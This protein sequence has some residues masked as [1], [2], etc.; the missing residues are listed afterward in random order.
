VPATLVHISPV[1]DVLC[2]RAP[3]PIAI[4][5]IPSLSVRLAIFSFVLDTVLACPQHWQRSMVVLIVHE[6][7]E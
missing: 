6:T 3:R 4:H 7:S 5:Y 2:R 1:R